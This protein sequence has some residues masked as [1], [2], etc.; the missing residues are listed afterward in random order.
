MSTLTIGP[1][2]NFYGTTYSGGN[3]NMGVVF[4]LGIP[5]SITTQPADVTVTNGGSVSIEATV[6]GTPL[7]YQ[8]FISSGRTATA[9]PYFVSLPGQVQSVIIIDGGEGYSSI[10]AVQFVGGI[11]IFSAGATAMVNNDVVTSINITT[12]GFYLS[13]PT[14]QI[15]SPSPIVN[16]PLVG[17][18][19]AVLTLTGVTSANTTNYF[20]VVTNTYGSVT[21]AVVGLTVFL[22]PQNFLG[23]SPDGQQLDLQLTGTPN[24]P[25]ILQ[26]ATNLTPP[27]IW[28]SILTN[29]AD[30][31]GNWSFTVSNLMNL[32]AGFYRAAAQ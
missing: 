1:D 26:S 24:Y 27:V 2:G 25:Y 8:W 17:Q 16:Q 9:V 31:N 20:V 15:G 18:T 13:Q 21:S 12:P 4:R 30:V 28:Q 6:S 23:F 14:I 22:P 32:P 3:N 7:S 19:N 10:P 11:V 29:P 5:P